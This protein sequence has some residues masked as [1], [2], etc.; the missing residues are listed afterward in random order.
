MNAMQIGKN[1]DEFMLIYKEFNEN[2]YDNGVDIEPLAMILSCLNSAKIYVVTN[3]GVPYQYLE[4]NP[5]IHT[6]LDFETCFGAFVPIPSNTVKDLIP[7]SV[8]DDQVTVPIALVIFPQYP[9][10]RME[11]VG[12]DGELQHFDNEK[13]DIILATDV[14][15]H[16]LN[17]KDIIM[18]LKR[19]LKSGGALII[20]LPCEYRLYRL[21]SRMKVKQNSERGHVYHSSRVADQVEAFT[22]NNFEK[23]YTANVYKF[24]CVTFSVME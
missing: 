4:E 16:N 21:F 13:F 19:I 3:Y 18:K 14:P 6:V 1:V 12:R 22:S 10:V 9:K 2:Y 24:I 7:D 15:E 20:L 8:F 11:K 17:Y 23:V 5:L